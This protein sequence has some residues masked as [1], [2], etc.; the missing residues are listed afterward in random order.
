MGFI[1][2]L[3]RYVRTPK[4]KEP[5]RKS[6]VKQ[7]TN[8]RQA[9][10][11]RKRTLELSALDR[12]FLDLI[13]IVV[14]AACSPADWQAMREANESPYDRIRRLEAEQAQR[15]ERA[16]LERRRQQDKRDRE[17]LA[18][19]AEERAERARALTRRDEAEWERYLAARASA[20][21][22]EECVA[23]SVEFEAVPDSPL[24]SVYLTDDGDGWISD[25]ETRRALRACVA[26][27]HEPDACT[28]RR[29][30]SPQ[31]AQVEARNEAAR[32][33]AEAEC[34]DGRP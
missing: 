9:I 22:L 5:K 13:S 29:V 1:D 32:Q 16:D 21:R 23:R 31:W 4:K 6:Q 20:Q 24:W 19:A 12:R 26:D 28:Q 8:Q 7:G 3:G 14:L 11:D 18:A 33:A 10:A 27:G 34:G 2:Q 30:T 15:E 25:R 17:R